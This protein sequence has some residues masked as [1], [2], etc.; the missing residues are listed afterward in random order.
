ME[1]GKKEI[2]VQRDEGGNRPGSPPDSYV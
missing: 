2:L 1:K